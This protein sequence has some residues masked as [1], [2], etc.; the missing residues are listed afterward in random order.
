MDF[1]MYQKYMHGEYDPEDG[2]M[3]IK[4]KAW[5]ERQRKRVELIKQFN[6][7]KEKYVNQEPQ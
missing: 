7:S 3:R 1:D 6:E 2:P 5:K 4:A